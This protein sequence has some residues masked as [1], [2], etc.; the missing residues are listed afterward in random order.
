MVVVAVVRGV[1][2]AEHLGEG[3]RSSD[4]P[5]GFLCC[6]QRKLVLDLFY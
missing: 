6:F 3:S 4:E 5:M 2:H 1:D